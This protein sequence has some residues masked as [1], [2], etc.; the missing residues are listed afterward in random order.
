VVGYG[1]VLCVTRLPVKGFRLASQLRETLPGS[2]EAVAELIKDRGRVRTF[3]TDPPIYAFYAG[4][5][6]HPRLAG[7]SLK[8]LYTNS[9]K[10]SDYRD[11][12]RDSRPEALLFARFPMLRDALRPCIGGYELAYKAPAGFAEV[13]ERKP[14]AEGG[15]AAAAASCARSAELQPNFSLTAAFWKGDD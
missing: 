4:L 3:L 6:L 12:L 11:I 2:F 14:D 5:P 1:L 8:T 7:T 10:L 13:Y 15:G 9:I